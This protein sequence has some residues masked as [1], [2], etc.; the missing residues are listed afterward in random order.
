MIKWAF[1]AALLGAAAM[2]GAANAAPASEAQWIAAATSAVAFAQA[3]GL[4]I[5]LVIEQG[6]GLPGHTPVGI[7]SE[8]GRC[9]LLVSAR[10]NPTADKVSAM[11][12]P[13]LQDLFLTGAAMHEVGHCFRRLQ[14]YPHNEKLLPVVAWIAPVRDWFARRVRTE[15]AYADMTEAA[16]LARF[17]PAQFDAVMN[18]VRKVR[19]RFREPKHDTL[20]WIDN[21]IVQGPSDNGQN[22]FLMAQQHLLAY[23]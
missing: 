10:D 18:E 6:D 21:A 7:A 19:L 9:T 23:Q 8:D 20:H 16:W 3:E 2:P 15:E 1:L 22:L 4:P 14:G 5:T 13:E 11:V 12:A 17:H